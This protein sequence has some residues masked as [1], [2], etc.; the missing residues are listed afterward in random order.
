MVITWIALGVL[1]S[2]AVA[3]IIAYWN[4]IVNWATNLLDNLFQRGKLFLRWVDGYL[5]P[6]VTGLLN[7]KAETE[8]GKPQP[9]TEDEIRQLY[10]EGVITYAEMLDLLA[11]KEISA[12]R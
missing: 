11:G 4:E 6:K 1:A 2:A 12:S 9:A 7:G 8:I 3:A 5:I 10:K